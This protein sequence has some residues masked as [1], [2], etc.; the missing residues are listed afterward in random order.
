MKIREGFVSNSSSSSFVIMK[1][2]LTRFQTNCLENHISCA[3]NLIAAG[4]IDVNDIGYFVREGDEWQIDG[5]T[6]D[7][8]F[9]CS[10]NMDN[11]DLPA[12]LREIGVPDEKMHSWEQ[13]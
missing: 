1:K 2:D 3:K 12:F 4:L 10:T 5:C 9:R 8:V 11:F 6:S 13:D 7:S